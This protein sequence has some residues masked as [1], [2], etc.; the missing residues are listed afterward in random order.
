MVESE[1]LISSCFN[2][3]DVRDYVIIVVNYF[4]ITKLLCFVS[5]ECRERSSR[6]LDNW[7]ST[8]CIK[9]RRQETADVLS[10]ENFV[11]YLSVCSLKLELTNVVFFTIKLQLLK[12]LALLYLDHDNNQQSTNKIK[13]MREK[14][15]VRRLQTEEMVRRDGESFWHIFWH[16]SSNKSQYLCV[17]FLSHWTFI[18][19]VHKSHDETFQQ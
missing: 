17:V 14:H 8:W 15:N 13:K 11:L 2:T 12:L 5:S 18:F 19:I 10:R 7:R 9:E 3:A 6:K 1:N 4:L 16:T